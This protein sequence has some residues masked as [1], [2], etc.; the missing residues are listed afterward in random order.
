M[1]SKEEYLDV[2]LERQCQ[3][4]ENHERGIHASGDSG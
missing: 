3:S 2:L 4:A 1:T